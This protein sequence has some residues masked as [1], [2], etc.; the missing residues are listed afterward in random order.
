M[1]R[2]WGCACRGGCISPPCKAS[3][4]VVTSAIDPSGPYGF[5]S[6]C[7][8]TATA[9]PPLRA[10]QDHHR[11][12]D[13]DD[14]VGVPTRFSRS[15]GRVYAPRIGSTSLNIAGIERIGNLEAGSPRSKGGA[16]AP[17]IGS[18]GLSIAGIERIT[19]QPS[20]SRSVRSASHQPPSLWINASPFPRLNRS[21]DTIGLFSVLLF[22]TLLSSGLR[23][24]LV[25]SR[26]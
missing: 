12:R 5:R 21:L 4:R 19:D 18:T 26:V 13:R 23:D 10:N 15:K 9:L 22:D 20:T 2:E 6:C 1:R 7:N 25:T 16:N 24:S 17:R 8:R 11:D 14:H 3:W